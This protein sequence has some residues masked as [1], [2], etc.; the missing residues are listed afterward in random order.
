[1]EISKLEKMI[2]EQNQRIEEL[3]AENRDIRKKMNELIEIN[4]KFVDNVIIINKKMMDM[5]KMME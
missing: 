2:I 5:A 4:K 3:E 1:M